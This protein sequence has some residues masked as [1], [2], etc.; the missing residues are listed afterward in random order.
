MILFSFYKLQSF[1]V[2]LYQKEISSSD[3]TTVTQITK[4]GAKLSGITNFIDNIDYKRNKC[5]IQSTK[6]TT[7]SIVQSPK[8]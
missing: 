4:R 2:F 6:L 1:S 3:S 5:Q 7:Q 8:T